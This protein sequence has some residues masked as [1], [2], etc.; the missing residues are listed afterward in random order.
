MD[1][2]RRLFGLLALSLAL[3]A[4]WAADSYKTYS[5]ARFGYRVL[6]P[7]FLTPQ[8]PPENNDG[9]EFHSSDGKIILAVWG[10]YNALDE[11]LADRYNQRLDELQADGNEPDYKVLRDTFYV[12]SYAG[13]RQISYERCAVSREQRAADAKP[14]AFSNLQ[15]IYDS[16]HKN[17]MDKV[18]AKVSGSLT[19]P[20]GE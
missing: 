9:R 3:G 12:I 1:T 5:N 17:R 7:T 2:K 19:G 13:G 6:Y 11:S 15:I 10:G 18:I 4:A 14:A 20:S 8:P 16:Y